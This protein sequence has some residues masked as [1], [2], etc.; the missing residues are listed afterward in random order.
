MS[1]GMDTLQPCAGM[2]MQ[3]TC[4]SHAD[5]MNQCMSHAAPL[6][7]LLAPCLLPNAMRQRVNVYYTTGTVG[8][9]VDHPKQSKTQLFRRNQTLAGLSDI[10]NNPRVHTGVGY[11]RRHSGLG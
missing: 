3:V 10:F 8:T 5:H 1:T 9:C 7:C 4:R 11:H 2:Q 6:Q